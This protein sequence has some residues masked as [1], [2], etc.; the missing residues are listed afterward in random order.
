MITLT[1]KAKKFLGKLK[2]KESDQLWG[3]IK[4][5]EKNPRPNC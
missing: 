1:R 2:Q 5:L 4:D 3:R